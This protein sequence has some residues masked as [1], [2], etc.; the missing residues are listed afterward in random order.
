MSL[1][2]FNQ[3][4]LPEKITHEQRYE[5]WAGIN[6]KNGGRGRGEG[7]REERGRKEMGEESRGERKVEEERNMDKG[8]EFT[9]PGFWE[10]SSVAKNVVSG[11]G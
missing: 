9:D 11:A 1:I 2:F 8:L 5:G 4:S 6:Q 3:E 7:R 10:N